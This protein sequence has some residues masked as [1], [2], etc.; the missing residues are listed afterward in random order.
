MLVIVADCISLLINGV[1]I[2]KARKWSIR[3]REAAERAELAAT[4]AAQEADRSRR[5]ATWRTS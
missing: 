3:A 5:A 4:Q 1:C 2:W